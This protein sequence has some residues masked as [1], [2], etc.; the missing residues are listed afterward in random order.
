MF[1]WFDINSVLIGCVCESIIIDQLFTVAV[2]VGGTIVAIVRV[3]AR[4]RLL[5]FK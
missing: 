2:D 4:L 5:P 1:V 3:V